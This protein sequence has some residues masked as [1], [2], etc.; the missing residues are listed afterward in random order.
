[1]RKFL[2]AI[3]SV[4]LLACL[5]IAVACSNK[6]DGKNYY[7]LVFRQTNGVHYVCDVKSGWEVKEGTTVNFKLEI[8]DDATGEPVVYANN[9]VLEAKS[10]NSYSVVITEDTVIRVDGLMAQGREYNKLVF[11]N[12]PGVLFTSRVEGLENGMMVK[13]HQMVAFTIAINEKYQGTPVVYANNTVLEADV[14]GVYSFEMTA[15]TT[16]RVEGLVKHIN[17]VYASGDTRVR[18]YTGD[19]DNKNYLV[20]DDAEDRVEGEEIEFKVQ[21]SV[22]NKQT[23]YE[24]LANQTILTPDSNGYYHFELVDDTTIRVNGLV[25]ATSFLD[26]SNGGLGTVASPFKISEPIDLYQ[27]AMQINSGWFTDGQFYKAHYELV[28]D[29]NLEGEQLYIIGDMSTGFSVFSGV[30]EG[31]GH[32][33]S[34]YT[35][36]D[37]WIDQ[38]SFTSRYIYNV[39]LFGYVIPDLD[40]YPAIYN[41]NLDNFTITADASKYRPTDEEP[42]VTLALGAIAGTA[43]GVDITGCSATNGEIVVT[44]GDYGGYIGGL[45]GQQVS[46][47]SDQMGLM[48]NTEIVSCHADV[49]VIID[50]PTEYGFAYAAGGITGLLI[51][52]EEHV[53]ATI[54]NSYSTGNVRGALNSGGIV[55]YAVA[56]SSVINCYSTGYINAY[57]HFEYNSSW[58]EEE[59]AQYQEY[60]CANAGGIVGRAGFN[61]V[62]YNCFST[63]ITYATSA[64]DEDFVKTSPIAAYLEDGDDLQD[65]HAYVSSIV[66]C[67]DERVTSLTENFIRNTMNWDEE[68]WLW[69]NG[70][71]AINYDSDGKQFTVSFEAVGDGNF[72]DI[73]EVKVDSRYWTMANWYSEGS[74]PEYRDGAQKGLRS[75]AYFF[76]AD[77]T[78]RVFFGF[79]PTGNITLYVGFADYSEI[80]GTY[81]LGT[82][83]TVS[84]KLELN[85]DGTAVYRNG[86][87]AHETTYTWDGETLVLL[88][89][90]LGELA[91][92]P[93]VEDVENANDYR[94]YYLSSTYVFG[95]TI[96]NG[97]ITITGGFVQEVAYEIG[98]IGY[99]D[100]GVPV[101]GPV[102]NTTG[103]TFR[104]FTADSALEGVIELENFIYGRYYD[105]GTTYQFNGNGTGLRTVNNTV[106]PFTYTVNGTSLSVKYAGQDAVSGTVGADGYVKT[107]ASATVNPYDGFT[108]TWERPFAVNMAYTFNGKGE[109]EEGE[110]TYSGYDNTLTASGTYTVSGNILTA[111]DGSFTA[112]IN[113]DGFLEITNRNDITNI[114]YMGGSFA[115]EWSYSYRLPGYT[116]TIITANISLYGISNNGYGTAYVEYGTGETSD[117]T[118]SA[119]YVGN[120]YKLSIYAN[121]YLYAS[122]TYDANDTVLTGTVDGIAGGRFTAYDNYRGLWISNDSVLSTVQFNGSGFNDLL[123]STGGSGPIAVRGTVTI[124]GISSGKYKIDHETMVGTYTYR[125]VEYTLRY[126]EQLDVINVQP[127]NGAAFVLMHRDNWYGRQLKDMNSGAVYT[128]ADGR[129][130]LEEG[131]RMTV[132][133]GS[134]YSYKL[135]SN[136]S[137]TVYEYRNLGSVV[138]TISVQQ[139]NSKSVFM[140]NKNVGGN[141]PLIRNTAFTGDWIIGGESGEIEIG[142][143]YADDKASGSY[144]FHGEEAQEIELEYNFE[145]NYLSFNYNGDTI[146]INVLSSS[147]A[148]ELSIGPDNSISGG[149][150]SICIAK[151]RADGYYDR[152]F[153]LYNITRHEDTGVTL[154]FDGL[155]ASVFGNAMAVTYNRDGGLAGAYVYSV[156]EIGLYI[157]YNYWRFYMVEVT[158]DVDMGAAALF[159]MH[160]GDTYYAMIRPD[161]LENVEVHDADDYSVTYVFNGVGGV[162]RRDSSGKVTGRYTYVV[163]LADNLNY[164]HVLKFIAED[165]TVYSVTLNQSN[166]QN[167]DEWTVKMSTPDKYFELVVKEAGE[168]NTEF[169]FD[170]T[171]RVV[172]LSNIDTTINYTYKLVSETDSQITFEF[173]TSEGGR[174]TAVVNKTGSDQSNWTITLSSVN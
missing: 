32:T 59:Y 2:L 124:E 60:W 104:I 72:G 170:G 56:G 116:N 162:T 52:G 145:N 84:A 112:K 149:N 47:Y 61:S 138:G 171:G 168:E 114:Y 69:K 37:T 105:S 26:R 18:Y 64:V 16:I 108:G 66:G 45:V 49:D 80:T 95:A 101:F 19:D 86:A 159:Y 130:N 158:K 131:G 156:N 73:P 43:F 137:I 78:Q 147:A 136:G 174:Y 143:I 88:Y 27:M 111:T 54:L 153:N 40:A 58:Q 125:G 122:L 93:A 71:P 81:Y 31:N 100:N 128:F 13:M 63:G 117:L 36:T 28:K 91:E 123:G 140:F 165:G 87:L 160:E 53:S 121:E 127:D 4:L 83:A 38:E 144:R 7:T 15:P 163:V 152:T 155:S 48:L 119:E 154:I 92:F 14:N 126:D 113:E 148:T 98:I 99:E 67:Y 169:L 34:N 44:S 129:G 97:R 90:Y 82:S 166:E 22:Y 109:T 10:E 17:L 29:I 133:D 68:D 39:G 62:I 35:M 142:E 51:V 89:S 79:I 77:C 70:A 173:T 132:D 76:D 57:S 65:A 8:D 141:V 118:Y 102:L 3:L 42:E 24:V 167:K 9:E 151:D 1:M 115:G 50:N 5:G 6:D 96:D 146:Y 25:E 106:T 21:I 85:P 157:M 120:T 20:T 23:G 103:R 74:I 11:A 139:Y 164:L 46:A 110:W 41:L 30:F 55:G 107:I 12:T 135:N 150:N 134:E 94:D 75:Y 33:I 161:E 172:R